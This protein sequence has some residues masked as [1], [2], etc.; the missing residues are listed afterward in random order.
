MTI[1]INWFDAFTASREALDELYPVL[2]HPSL[3]DYLKRNSLAIKTR[4]EF[5]LRIT[6]RLQEDD[7]EED[8]DNR[9]KEFEEYMFQ[10]LECLTSIDIVVLNIKVSVCP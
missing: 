5:G 4:V 1:A 10:L 6:I 7:L 2:Y 3:L 8:E 9:E